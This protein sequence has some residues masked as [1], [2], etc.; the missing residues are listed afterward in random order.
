MKY[1]NDIIIPNISTPAIIETIMIITGIT[2]G[3][4]AVMSD[5]LLFVD[6]GVIT[7]LVDVSLAELVD[8]TLAVISDVLLFIDVG[9]IVELV[10]RGVVIPWVG[11]DGVTSPR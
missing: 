6:V 2:G 8:G 3:T 1:N 11:Y 9:V 5:L 7:E 10:I 4:L